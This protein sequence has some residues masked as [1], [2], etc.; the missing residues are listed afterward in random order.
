[1][2]VAVGTVGICGTDVPATQGLFPWKPP[3]VME[4]EYSGTIV[5]SAGPAL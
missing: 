5:W 2:L 1:V 4:H 3:L